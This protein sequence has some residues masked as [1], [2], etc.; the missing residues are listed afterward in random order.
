MCPAFVLRRAT[1]LYITVPAFAKL[2]QRNRFSG[3]QEHLEPRDEGKDAVDSVRDAAEEGKVDDKVRR[4]WR[5]VG[6][7]AVPLLLVLF[8]AFSRRR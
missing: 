5:A 1:R 4:R 8:S 2:A 7:R 6:Y 3:T